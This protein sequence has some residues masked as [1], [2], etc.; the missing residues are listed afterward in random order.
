MPTTKRALVLGLLIASLPFL[1]LACKQS[2]QAPP[3][4]LSLWTVYDNTDALAPII[5]AFKAAHPNIDIQVR[6]VRYDDYENELLNAWAED[7]GPDIFSL[8]NTWIGKYVPKIAPLPPTVTL[9]FTYESGTIK[10]ELVTEMRTIPSIT[11]AQIRDQY[12]DVVGNDVIRKDAQGAEQVLGL[13]LSMDTLVMYYNKDILNQAGIATV[14]TN[15]Q[16]LLSDISKIT[17]VDSQGNIVVSGAALGTAT[18]IPRASDIVST[19]MMQNGAIMTD[20]NG[21]PTF[22]DVPPDAADKSYAPGIDAL[23]FYTDFSDPEKLAYSWNDKMPDALEAFSEGRVGFFFG[24]AYDIPTLKA[25]APQ[26]RW[27]LAEI[28]QISTD[29]RTNFA[30]YWVETVS[31][32]SAHQAEAWDFIQF[33]T[34][35]DTVQNYLTAAEVP[36]ALRSLIDTQKSDPTLQPFSDELLTAKSW[37]RGNDVGAAE[38][39]MTDLIENTPAALASQDKGAFGSLVATEV[40]KISETVRNQPQ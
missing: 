32:K 34:D 26:L 20:G 22:Q 6:Q 1:G 14:P 19:L 38:Q 31:K 9:P 11:T 12:I 18:N 8:H 25:N 21:F 5:S 7:R 3:V 28:P 37:Y 27:G 16:E 35:K 29:H 33:A 13:P 36:T 30:N 10:K 24:Y 23:K 4:T 2:V 39:A 17:K 15:W 40:S